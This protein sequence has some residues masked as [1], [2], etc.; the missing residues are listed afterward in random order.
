MSDIFIVTEGGDEPLDLSRSLRD[1]NDELTRSAPMSEGPG[2]VIGGSLSEP[3][4]ESTTPTV[5]YRI[6]EP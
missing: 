5:I 2:G 3:V 4:D 1:A 6:A